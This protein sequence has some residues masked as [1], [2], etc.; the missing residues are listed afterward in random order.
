MGIAGGD[1]GGDGCGGGGSSA[2]AAAAEAAAVAADAA[3]EAEAVAEAVSQP[4][5]GTP[6]VEAAAPPAAELGALPV[7]GAGTEAAAEPEATAPRDLVLPLAFGRLNYDVELARGDS[8]MGASRNFCRLEWERLRPE[9]AAVLG[10][11]EGAAAPS[12]ALCG[13]LVLGVVAAFAAAAPPTPPSLDA[14]GVNLSGTVSL[15]IVLGSS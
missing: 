10:E 2:A 8:L 14:G 3:A 7:A 6:A 4:N 11:G 5:S 1:G 9:M 13:E 15:P 12:E